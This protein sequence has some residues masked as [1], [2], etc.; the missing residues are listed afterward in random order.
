MV[1]SCVSY[2]VLH[3]AQIFG[4]LGVAVVLS[5]VCSCEA[6][7]VPDAQVHPIDHKDLTALESDMR[8]T[9][10]V[11][12]VMNKMEKMTVAVNVTAVH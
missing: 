4:T 10:R 9:E 5:Q 2:H 11:V 3:S 12:E 8:G 1:H 7:L 6:V